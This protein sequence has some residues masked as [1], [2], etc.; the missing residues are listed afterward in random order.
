NM[1]SS[2]A[3]YSGSRST[4]CRSQFSVMHVLRQ[5]RIDY[6]SLRKR[7][8]MQK[9][10]GNVSMPTYGGPPPSDRS[11]AVVTQSTSLTTRLAGLRSPSSTE[12]QMLLVLTK[13]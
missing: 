12:S 1:P 9:L 6:H 11:A 7:L 2:Q 4:T 3:R 13:G 10:M 8:T 5:S